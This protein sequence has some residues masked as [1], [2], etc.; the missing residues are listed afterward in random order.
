MTSAD[1][2]NTIVDIANIFRAES[3][4]N[5]YNKGGPLMWNERDSQ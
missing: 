5:G 4:K 2:T 1:G 3:G